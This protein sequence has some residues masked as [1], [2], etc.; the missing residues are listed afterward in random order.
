MSTIKGNMSQ[1]YVV[2]FFF[3]YLSLLTDTPCPYDKRKIG[4]REKAHYAEDQ[5]VKMFKLRVVLGSGRW[6]DLNSL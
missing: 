1:D 4:R 5:R 2:N 6:K 3:V